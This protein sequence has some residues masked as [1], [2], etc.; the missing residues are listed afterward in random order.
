MGWKGSIGKMFYDLR[1]YE[2]VDYI[3][4]YLRIYLKSWRKAGS[5][6]QRVQE[7]KNFKKWFFFYKIKILI[8]EIRNSK[9]LRITKEMRNKKY[10]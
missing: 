6:P 1:V 8:K 9:K 7:I 4:A 3:G 10:K 5:V 2:S